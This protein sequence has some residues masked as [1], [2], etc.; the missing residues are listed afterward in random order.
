MVPSV[1]RIGTDKNVCHHLK[2]PEVTRKGSN[3]GGV[4]E[5]VHADKKCTPFLSA[6]QKIWRFFSLKISVRAAVLV[7][8]P[9]STKQGK[10]WSRFKCLIPG[11]GGWMEG[12]MEEGCVE[13]VRGCG[14]EEEEIVGSTM[15][16]ILET[17]SRM[18]F[19]AHF[20]FFSF[21]VDDFMDL[22][23][24]LQSKVCT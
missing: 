11:G 15:H 1:Y 10:G 9:S 19:Q 21:P 24:T 23:Y 7:L 18:V 16:V 3:H 17:Q 6:W 13:E 12:R 8:Q 5:N 14:E 20:L 22:R 4:I 2:Y